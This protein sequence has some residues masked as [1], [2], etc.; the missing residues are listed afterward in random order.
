MRRHALAELRQVEEGD[1]RRPVDHRPRTPWLAL[2]SRR[3][4]EG[5]GIG[6]HR[7]DD[8]GPG[9]G[10]R[11]HP[12]RGQPPVMVELD[13]V[14][15]VERQARRRQAEGRGLAAD[16][17]L[18]Q[19]PAAAPVGVLATVAIAKLSEVTRSASPVA[20]RASTVIAS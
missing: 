11:G 13:D 19:R 16:P 5:G 4:A 20:R 10:D 17:F 6:A 3:E 14:A 8:P 2:G 12:E 1:G 15:G 7:L 9:V 18:E